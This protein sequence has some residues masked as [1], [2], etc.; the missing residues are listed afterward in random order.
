LRSKLAEA[1][2]GRSLIHT[3]SGIGYRFTPDADS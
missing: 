2:P 1:L 3:Y